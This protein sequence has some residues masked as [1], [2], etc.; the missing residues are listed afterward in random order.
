MCREH[1]LDGNGGQDSA[2]ADHQYE[3][4]PFVVLYN[5]PGSTVNSDMYLATLKELGS[6]G[7]TRENLIENAAFYKL[8]RGANVQ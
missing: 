2:E 6:N 1:K 7:K 4:N 3:P 8:M 5:D